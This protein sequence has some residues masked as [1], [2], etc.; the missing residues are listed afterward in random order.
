[1]VNRPQSLF[2]KCSKCSIYAVERVKLYME[3]DE[4]YMEKLLQQ[5]F[6]HIHVLIIVIVDSASLERRVARDASNIKCNFPIRV[7]CFPSEG[8]FQIYLKSAA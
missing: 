3:F 6:N 4:L 7:S 2:K 1:M 8:G 5:R